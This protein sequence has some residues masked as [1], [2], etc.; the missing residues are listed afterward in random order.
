VEAAVRLGDVLLAEYYST[1]AYIGPR[2][3][4]WD[5]P[6]PGDVSMLGGTPN[7]REIITYGTQENNSSWDQ[8]SLGFRPSEY[9]LA[10]AAEGADII[11]KYLDG[12]LSLMREAATYNS[13]NEILKYYLS[14]KLLNPYVY[15][16]SRVPPPLIYDADAGAEVAD[17][18]SVIDPYFIQKVAE[19]V[20]GTDDIEG[21]FA[22]YVSEL[23]SMGLNTLVSHMQA[24]FEIIE[25]E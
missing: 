24:A 21:G 15:S 14:K 11:Y 7:R 8:A 6:N 16:A 12:D 20:M 5:Y 1:C 23:E 2:G 4:G 10:L 13:Y 17:I 25:L 22:N 18:K 3:M 9:R 19:F